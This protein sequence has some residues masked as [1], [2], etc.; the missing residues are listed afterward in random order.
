MVNSDAVHLKGDIDKSLSTDYGFWTER[1][2]NSFLTNEK[3]K[4]IETDSLETV[5]RMGH[6]SKV[7]LC[8]L[9][10]N[11]DNSCDSS[12]SATTTTTT[13]EVESTEGKDHALHNQEKKNQTFSAAGTTNNKDLTVI[14]ENI[15]II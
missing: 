7:K 3:T 2:M 13:E 5:E 15:E 9:A 11:G 10:E 1:I 4:Q 8:V 12:I 6:D 14:N